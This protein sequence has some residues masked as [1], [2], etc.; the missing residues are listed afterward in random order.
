MRGHH[1]GAD[2]GA[3]DGRPHHRGAHHA[4][5]HHVA[6]HHGV[7]HHSVTYDGGA[8]DIRPD[9]TLPDHR[10][11]DHGDANHGR[12]Y[13]GEDIPA[14]VATVDG[15][16]VAKAF[17]PTKGYPGEGPAHNPSPDAAELARR[18][19]ENERRRQREAQDP[20]APARKRDVKHG[21]RER[22]RDQR[23]RAAGPNVRGAC[24]ITAPTGASQA[25]EAHQP[26]ELPYRQGTS[27][28]RSGVRRYPRDG[29]LARELMP[30]MAVRAVHT[31]PA[32]GRLQQDRLLVHTRGGSRRRAA[33][34]ARVEAT[35]PAKVK[36][37]VAFAGLLA[38]THGDED[39]IPIWHMAPEEV[40]TGRPRAVE[41]ELSRLRRELVEIPGGLALPPAK[42]KAA[43]WHVPTRD[44]EYQE[45]TR[46][47][48]V[49][50]AEARGWRR[51]TAE[52]R[53]ARRK[54]EAQEAPRPSER[55]TKHPHTLRVIQFNCTSWTARKTK[56]SRHLLCLKP[57]VRKYDLKH[58]RDIGIGTYQWW[59]R[60]ER[61]R[62][63]CEKEG[64]V[65]EEEA[66]GEE[67]KVV[68]YVESLRDA[69]VVVTG[70]LVSATATGV[71]KTFRPAALKQNGGEV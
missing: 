52:Q 46:K 31:V 51:E 27:A 3:H 61:D 16:A 21:V 45:T 34:E 42:G 4:G 71:V 41:R 39:H 32:A 10:R 25:I 2:G 6:T 63:A 53:E 66:P 35:F 64:E 48:F 19:A 33:L 54:A 70:R 30:N 20:D 26:R 37:K 67:T 50:A 14:F 62:K 7:S 8:G 5:A 12:C 58:A 55:M 56:V 44:L 68:Q 28:G 36:V 17:N 15:D 40:A 38:D 43:R 57:D 47:K 1:R 49:A 9:H 13:N 11:A 65:G 60:Q 22:Q 24:I 59:G 23:S 29:P 69:G 18:A